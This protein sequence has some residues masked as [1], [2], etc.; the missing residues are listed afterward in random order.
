MGGACACRSRQGSSAPP[1]EARESVLQKVGQR[2]YDLEA[3]AVVWRCDRA[4]VLTA[5]KEDGRALQFA[6]DALK[7]DREIVLAAVQEN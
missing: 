6:A 1:T 7:G 4:V 3:V 2:G 5:V